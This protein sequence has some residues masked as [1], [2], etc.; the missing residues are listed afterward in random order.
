MEKLRNLY[1]SF[2]EKILDWNVEKLWSICG[3]STHWKITDWKIPTR[4]TMEWYAKP[5]WKVE[6]CFGK[7]QTVQALKAARKF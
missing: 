3:E 5:T 1:G 4:D 6:K 2:M 7:L